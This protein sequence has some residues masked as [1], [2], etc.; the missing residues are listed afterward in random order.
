[1][2]ARVL[3]PEEWD[4]LTATEAPH[5]ANLVPSRDAWI[6]VAEDGDEI[7]GVLTIFKGMHFEGLW[8]T[9]ERRNAGVIRSLLRTAGGIAREDEQRIVFA[10]ADD[11]KMSGIMQRL[12][13]ARL[14]SE[15]Y[16]LP[17]GS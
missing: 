5:Y 1:M 11:E 14:P 12:G 13:G 10:T 2:T 17:V 3:P 7:I 16:V 4:R 15:T 6:V 8:T 9:P